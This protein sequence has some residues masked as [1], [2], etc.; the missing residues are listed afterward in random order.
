MV[1]LIATLV[2]LSFI[3]TYFVE[4]VDKWRVL[5]WMYLPFLVPAYWA[6]NSSLLSNKS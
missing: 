3:N 1:A 5:F 4:F 6:A 2:V